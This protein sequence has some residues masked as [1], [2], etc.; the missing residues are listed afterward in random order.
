MH[1]KDY[2]GLYYYLTK[3]I[4]FSIISLYDTFV[5]A[6]T[7]MYNNLI[8][9]NYEKMNLYE[10]YYKKNLKIKNFSRTVYV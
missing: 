4:L 8:K 2:F 10:Q 5:F 3:H 7:I 9:T 6:C 1:I